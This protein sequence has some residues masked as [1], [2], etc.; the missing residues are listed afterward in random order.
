MST[1]SFQT[2]REEISAYLPV[3][4]AQKLRMITSLIPLS[5]SGTTIFSLSIILNSDLLF[6][7]T[8][9][10]CGAK[11]VILIGHG[12]GCHSL[13]RLME[14]RRVYFSSFRGEILKLSLFDSFR[15]LEMCKSCDSNCRTAKITWSSHIIRRNSQLVSEGM[16]WATSGMQLGSSV[17]S[18]PL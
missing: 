11:E 18:I 15:H 14:R 2:L 9:R 4:S 3:F 1:V 5:T 8:W 13:V 7:P 16:H 10:L 12:P 17:Y 6:M